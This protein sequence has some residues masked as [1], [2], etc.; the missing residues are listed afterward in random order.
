VLRAFRGETINKAY[1]NFMNPVELSLFSSRINSVC[2]EMGA[3]LKR[4]AFSPNIKDRLDYSCAIFDRQGQICAQAAHIP[5]HLGSMAYAMV[6]IVEGIDWNPG[7]M[8]IVNDPF[9][10]GTHLPDI[11]LIA[12][13]FFNN[14]LLG[15]TAN[16]AH[17]ADAGCDT[18]GSMPVSSSILEEGMLIPPTC[19]IK[20]GVL[21]EDVMADLTSK[22]RDKAGSKGDFTAQISANKC[23]LTRLHELIS[24][25]S[26][27]TWLQALIDL[28]DY[29]EKLAFS[30]LKKIPEGC[31]SFTDVLD[32]DGQ[33]QEDIPIKATI[34]I[35][36]AF[37][38]VNF[39]GTAGQTSGNLNCPLSVAAAAVYYVFYCLMPENTPACHGC[40]RRI[41][42]RA[43]EKS[44]L[45]A[46]YPAAVAAGNVETSTRIVDVILGALAN[47]LPDL[48]PAASHGSMNNI[49]MGSDHWAYYETIGGGM[50]ASKNA[51]GL[52][53]VQTHMTNTLNT[54]V[55]ILELKFPLRITEYAIRENVG[56]SGEHQG[57]NGIIRQYEFLENTSVTV[58][59][60]R[61]K[62]A[63][64][65]LNAEGGST[66]VN[67]LNSR[68][69]PGKYQFQAIKGDTLCIKTAGG[70]GWNNLQ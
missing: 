29:A 43:P 16:R 54:P 19:I 53:A 1:N 42:I 20:N 67:T 51:N 23:G 66:G 62:H 40:F 14:Q 58:L 7:D 33:G 48:I 35:K 44:L 22:C 8:I 50:G 60:E 10:G 21:C 5:V 41:K 30:N 69:I 24:Q 11:T 13:F 63:P 65:G 3:V 46:Q 36:D 26:E 25:S 27:D 59:S 47:A 9:R 15:F 4:T 17:H 52:D 31:Y 56:G 49:A 2:E 34:T 37:V 32:D 57:G 38:D 64:W 28:N 12:P 55:E 68:K 39:D 18:P 70:G 6:D 45:N 61:R